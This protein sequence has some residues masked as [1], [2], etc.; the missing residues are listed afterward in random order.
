MPGAGDALRALPPHKDGVP[1][2]WKVTNRNKKGVTLDLHSQTGRDLL[3][4]LLGRARRAGRE[5]PP[6]HARPLGH[7]PP[8]AAGDQPAAH[9]PPR[10]R[11]RADRAVQEP[12]GL[13][14]R[15]RGD[16]RLHAHVR[17]GRRHAAPSRVP[18]LGRDRRPLRRARRARRAVPPEGGSVVARAGDRL[19]DDRGDA[20]HARFPRDRVRPARR[21]AHR[22]RQPQPVRGAGEHLRHARRQV[23]LD[24]R[25]DPEHLRAA[26]RRARARGAPRGSRAL[27]TTRRA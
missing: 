8:V 7:H 12:P 14:P 24:R 21:G 23:G 4:K 2:W 5:L 9:D 26:V 10:D 22:E 17:R 27:P 18:D 20:A 13:R 25:L 6:R 11:L 16:E 1:L 3:A 19:L 15:V